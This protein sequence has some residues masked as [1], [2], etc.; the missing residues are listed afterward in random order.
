MRGGLGGTWPKD[1]PEEAERWRRNAEANKA[2][3][4]SLVQNLVML[5]VI[6]LSLLAFWYQ[7][8]SEE[9]RRERRMKNRASRLGRK[10]NPDANWP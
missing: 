10:G 5:A 3:E 1:T 4:P 2:N 6:L 7:K 8:R 9:M